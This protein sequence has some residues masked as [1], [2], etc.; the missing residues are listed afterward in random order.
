MLF[1]DTLCDDGA[2]SA[3]E[4][5]G[6][7]AAAVEG[8]VDACSASDDPSNKDGDKL[9]ANDA[10][11]VTS[12]EESVTVDGREAALAVAGPVLHEEFATDDVRLGAGDL[13]MVAAP[14]FTDVSATEGG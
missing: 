12:P 11:A 8:I 2:N 10:S 1:W 5:I 7:S 6:F 4:I 14:E 13:S 9:G 3:V